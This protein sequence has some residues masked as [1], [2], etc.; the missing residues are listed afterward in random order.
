MLV[1]II[2]KDNSLFEQLLADVSKT[3]LPLLCTS[4]ALGSSGGRS[5]VQLEE[6][7]AAHGGRVLWDLNISRFSLI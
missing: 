7:A 4:S 1:S 3:V 2:I 5:L 6:K